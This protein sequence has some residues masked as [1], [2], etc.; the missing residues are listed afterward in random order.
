VPRALDVGVKDSRESQHVISGA[1][2]GLTCA[3]CAD[4]AR[5]A[6]RLLASCDTQVA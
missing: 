1:H 5:M 3:F 4:D 2:A 6:G